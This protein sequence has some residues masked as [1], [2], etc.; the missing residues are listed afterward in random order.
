MFAFVRDLQ[1][2]PEFQALCARPYHGHP[3]GCPNCGRRPSCPPAAPLI[4]RVL[5]LSEPMFVV[6]TP[7]DL[8][9]HIE[10]MRR[11]HPDWSE[12]QLRCCLYWQGTARKQHR[13]AIAAN[14]PWRFPNGYRLVHTP[15]GHGVN[16]TVLMASLGAQSVTLEWPPEKTSY[17][18]S[19]GGTACRS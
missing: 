10:K 7:F 14:V 5:D 19:I 12:R 6:A 15:E 8:G 3:H 16:V 11:R 1:F 2:G 4:D 17:V 13:Q 18:V 9:W